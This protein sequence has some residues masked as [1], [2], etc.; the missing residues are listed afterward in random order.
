VR[1]RFKLDNLGPLDIRLVL[2]GMR[3][4]LYWEISR[5]GG[6]SFPRT[7]A[8][9]PIQESLAFSMICH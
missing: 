4:G 3:V 8:D 2:K 9:Q 6:G 1:I 7:V 5:S